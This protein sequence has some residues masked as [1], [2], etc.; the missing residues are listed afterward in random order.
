MTVVGS[1]CH[2]Q[3]GGYSGIRLRK[4]NVAGV[5]MLFIVDRL[6]TD[7]LIH[8]LCVC[9]NHGVSLHLFVSEYV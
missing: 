4:F 5:V 3:M 7:L 8:I 6:S 1:K 2:C 9:L